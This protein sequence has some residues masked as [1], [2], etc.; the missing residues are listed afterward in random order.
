[1]DSAHTT[2]I[3]QIILREEAMLREY[4]ETRRKRWVETLEQRRI[5]ELHEHLK[6]SP[7]HD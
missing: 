5:T 2:D 3:S 1:M 7:T 4:I 6:A